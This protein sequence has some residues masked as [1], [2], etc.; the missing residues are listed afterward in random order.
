MAT[1]TQ[2]KPAESDAAAGTKPKKSKKKLVLILV[3][4][5]LVAVG[6]Y[7]TMGKKS[8][9]PAPPQPG[10]V[11]PLEPITINL[12][13]GHFLKLGIAMQ[14]TKSAK[15]TVDG[16]QALDLAIEVFSNRT[17]EELGTNKGRTK[18]KD[19]LRKKIIEAYQTENVKE[20][21]DVYFTE[22]VMQ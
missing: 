14:A 13:G 7:L 21:M 16:S 4:L 8:G 22:F 6:G 10:V 1:T 20:V 2:L 9:P 3:P 12:A 15:E 17:V 18:F 11:V 5:L 19:D